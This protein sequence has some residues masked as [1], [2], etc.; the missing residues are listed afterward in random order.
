MTTDLTGCYL[1]YDPGGNDGHG[2]ASFRVDQ[3]GHITE[4]QSDTRRTVQGVLDWFH[5]TVGHLGSVRAVGI[6]TLTYW[7]SRD[8]GWRDADEWLRKRYE[9]ASASVVALNSMYSSMSVN[10]M[11]VLLR[12]REVY[13]G[14]YVTETH[15]KVLHFALAAG[16]PEDRRYPSRRKKDGKFLETKK[17]FEKRVFVDSPDMNRRLADWTKVDIGAL[18]K[19]PKNSHEWDALISAWAAFQAKSRKWKIDLVSLEEDRDH[20]LFP[21]AG[22]EYRWPDESWLAEFRKKKRGC[23]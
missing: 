4:T 1:G 6:D 18:P 17:A 2:V 5:G 21:S 13:P 10:G 23:G 14:L 11:F 22:V 8:S 12:L 19:K 16:R 3:S 15:P 9:N 7:S 20:L